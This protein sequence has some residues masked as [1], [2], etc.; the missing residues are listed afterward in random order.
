MTTPK[1]DYSNEFSDSKLNNRE[2]YNN[3]LSTMAKLTS[4]Q[5][6]SQIYMK[7][8]PKQKTKVG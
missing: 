6:L 3:N 7:N 1:N 5:K 2:F 8:N 4:C